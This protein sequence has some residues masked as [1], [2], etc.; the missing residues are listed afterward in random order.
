MTVDRARKHGPFDSRF[1]PTMGE[2]RTALDARSANARRQVTAPLTGWKGFSTRYFGGSRR[3]DMQALAGYE[4]Y[5][6]ASKHIRGREQAPPP[7]SQRIDR[8]E[9]EGGHI[10]P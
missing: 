6:N 10:T 4:A 1:P 8:W 2:S 5:R 3:H 9:N 7:Q